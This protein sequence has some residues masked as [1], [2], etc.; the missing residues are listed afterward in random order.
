MNK[1]KQHSQGFSILIVIALLAVVAVVGFAGYSV[2]N[3]TDGKQDSQ[4]MSNDP[5]QSNQSNQQK[6]NSQASRTDDTPIELQNIGLASFDDID[7]N[8]YAVRDFDSQGMKGFYVFGDPLPGGRT[9]PNFEFSSVK[10]DAQVVAVM[11]GVIV[12]IQEQNEN[13]MTDYE[14]FLQT[15]ENSIW[16]IGYDHLINLAVKKGDRVKAGD[17]LGNPNVQGNGLARFELQVNK[18]MSTAEHICPTTLLAS[19]VKNNVLNN[20]KTMMNT[21]EEKTGLEL[22]NPDAHNPVGCKDK[23]TLTPAE[24]EG[25]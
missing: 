21:W 7:Y 17:F 11:D 25:R 4:Q 12:H 9:N 20:L 1:H 15:S 22:Y 5:N 19:S 23:T 3:K 14:V 13:N 18:E 6:Q 8:P 2:M 10:K 16:M 24:A